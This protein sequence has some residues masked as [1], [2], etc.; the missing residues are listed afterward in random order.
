MVWKP[1]VTVAAVV[2]SDGKFLLVEEHTTEGIRLNQ[3]AGHLE[4]GESLSAAVSRETL[5]ETAHEFVPKQ[6]TGI[7]RW[8]KPD[9]DLT[10]L[11]FAFSGILGKHHADRELDDGIIRAVWLDHSE[12]A[13]SVERHR[14]PLVLRCVEDYLSG[15]R[16]GMEALVDYSA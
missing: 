7:Y 4:A 6:L 10:Y 11:R 16:F 13:G 2:E 15:R 12:I 5:E 14:S 9:S 1:E 3:P 8:S